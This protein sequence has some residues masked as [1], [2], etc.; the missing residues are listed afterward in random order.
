M[1]YRFVDSFRAGA[2]Q[3][4]F[5]KLVH[6]VAFITNKCTAVTAGKI[7]ST[8]VWQIPPKTPCIYTFFV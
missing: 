5:V 3:N 8:E 7:A 2:L 6:L 1:S 4:K